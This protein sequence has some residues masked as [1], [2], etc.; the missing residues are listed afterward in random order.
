MNTTAN[1]TRIRWWIAGLMWLA[2]AINY[3]DRTV[4]SAA[5][6]HLIDELKLDPEMMG[7]IMAAFF[8]HTRYY[9][10]PPGGSPIVLVRKGLGLAVARWSIA[11]SMMGV[12]TGFKSLL[13]L[14]LALGV[15]EAAAYPSNAGIAARWFPDKERATV[16]GLFD[17][18]SKFGGAI[19]MP[20]IVWMI[21]T[22][23]WRLT[24]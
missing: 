11:T 3:I 5:A 12:A 14:R 4:L 1:T 19:A 18:A 17:S 20:L 23:D 10:S 7:F 15:G 13:A 22:F 8:G 9:R 24:F 6:P 16:S 21:Y 2:I